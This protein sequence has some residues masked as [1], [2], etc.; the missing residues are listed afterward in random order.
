MRWCKRT[1]HL[2]STRGRSCHHQELQQVPT[3]LYVLLPSVD[4]TQNLYNFLNIGGV[5]ENMNFYNA[6]PVQAEGVK[7][8]GRRVLRRPK[9]L[10]GT[11]GLFFVL[12]V[13]RTGTSIRVASTLF[14]VSDS[15]GGR[16][17]TGWL[18]LLANSLRPLV[19]LPDVGSV[20]S[21]APPNFEREGLSSVAVVLDGTEIWCEKVWQSDAQHALWSQYKKRYTAKILIGIIPAGAICYVS[22]AYVGRTSDVELVR[23][24]GI[25]EDLTELGFGGKGMHVMADRG[26]NAMAPLLIDIGMHYVAPPSKRKGEHQFNEEDASVTREV[27]NLRIHVERAIGAMKQWRILETKFDSQ[28]MD[29]IGEIALVCAAM[30]NLTRKPFASA[31]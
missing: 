26:F 5:A 14:G 3:L 4:A 9:K 22:D 16:A 23:Q 7:E 12:F 1:T 18:D 6:N 19:R 13:L 20:V 29:N 28:Q 25:V 27:A 30:V 17:F 21:S 15:T 11:N 31:K 2:A 10:G 24:C 8:D